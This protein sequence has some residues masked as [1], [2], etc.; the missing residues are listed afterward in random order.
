MNT[1][2]L[3]VYR[4]TSVY[5]TPILPVGAADPILPVGAAGNFI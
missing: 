4:N 1:S 5:L 3:V 2:P